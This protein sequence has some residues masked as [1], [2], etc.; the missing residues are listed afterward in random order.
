MLNNLLTISLPGVPQN[1]CEVRVYARH[2]SSPE[3]LHQGSTG[4]P[5]HCCAY[6][7]S[8]Y[9]RC[10]AKLRKTIRTLF[11]LL[12]TTLGVNGALRDSPAQVPLW[13]EDKVTQPWGIGLSS[14]LDSL[15]SRLGVPPPFC[16][17]MMSQYGIHLAFLNILISSADPK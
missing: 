16:S 9:R 17:E 2:Y 1:V 13:Q 14:F 15:Y 10:L 5:K 11:L 3:T 6:Y 4:F 12:K 7:Q 8:F